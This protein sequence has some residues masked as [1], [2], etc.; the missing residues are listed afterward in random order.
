MTALATAAAFLLGIATGLIG[1]AWITAPERRRTAADLSDWRSAAYGYRRLYSESVSRE[2][3]YLARYGGDTPL[4]EAASAAV[5][6]RGKT[7]DQEWA[8]LNAGG[9][10]S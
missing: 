5:E 2:A 3:V 8:D 7:I 1:Y 9:G 10:L 6:A 4:A